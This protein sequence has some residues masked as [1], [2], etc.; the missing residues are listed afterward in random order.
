MNYKAPPWELFL[1]L[2]VLLCSVTEVASG[3]PWCS[4][5]SLVLAYR[6]L[7]TFSWSE[8]SV[9]STVRIF[10]FASKSPGVTVLEIDYNLA[11]NL[12]GLKHSDCHASFASS[13]SPASAVDVG[14][15]VTGAVVWHY[16]LDVFNVHSP[17]HYICADQPVTNMRFYARMFYMAYI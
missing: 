6:L 16:T 5:A 2:P 9:K 3:Y 14:F 13:A 8:T 17:S 10:I 7:D 1:V 12:L 4:V 15:E 11:V